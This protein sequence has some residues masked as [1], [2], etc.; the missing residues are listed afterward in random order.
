MSDNE[1]QALR[2]ELQALAERCT[3]LE[4]DNAH[5]H[6]L[7]NA[8]LPLLGRFQSTSTWSPFQSPEV[9]AICEN[10]TEQEHAR[11]ITNARLTGYEIGNWVISPMIGLIASAFLSF[12][13]PFP[14]IL[15]FIACTWCVYAHGIPRMRNMRHR[16]REILCETNYAKQKGYTPS[17]LSL[18]SLPWSRP[19]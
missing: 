16:V 15:L 17:A 12:A 7:A 1:T 13:A 4:R 6:D 3:K 5:L 11:L 9:Q 14:F 18:E 19:G 2:T 8:S 10:L